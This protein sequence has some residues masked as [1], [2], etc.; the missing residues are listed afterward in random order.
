MTK[1][2]LAL[3]TM[4]SVALVPSATYARASDGVLGGFVGFAAGLITSAALANNCRRECVVVHEPA[5]IEQPIIVERPVI[6]QRPV[7]IERRI[8]QRPII[9]KTII[10][11]ECAQPCSSSRSEKELELSLLRE[12][13][14]QKE[15]A[16]R[17]KELNLRVAQ[18]Q[19]VIIEKK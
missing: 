15:L 4:M 12:R 14:K 7:M 19:P 6:V 2:L 17:E 1:K 8:I 16:L 10:T 18:T 3:C 13:N 5:F 9:R 11:K